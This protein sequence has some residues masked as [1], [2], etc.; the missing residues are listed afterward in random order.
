MA[1]EL[2]AI[3]MSLQSARTIVTI[4]ITIT[5]TSDAPVMALVPGVTAMK[6]DDT[7]TMGTT[8]GQDRKIR[9]K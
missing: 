6:S 3:V 5:I 1:S 7:V 9:T 2:N 8:I 4:T